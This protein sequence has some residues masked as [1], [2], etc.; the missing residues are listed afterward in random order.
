[1]KPT[2]DMKPPGTRHRALIIQIGHSQN[3]IITDGTD[4]SKLLER[5]NVTEIKRQGVVDPCI[6]GSPPRIKYYADLSMSN[7]PR[8]GPFDTKEEAVQSEMDYLLGGK[9]LQEKL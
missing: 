1:M 4:H 5:Y 2:K 9:Y 6:I 7:G 3:L 8:L